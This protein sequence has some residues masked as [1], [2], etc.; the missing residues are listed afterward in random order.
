MTAPREF[1]SFAAVG[2]IGFAVD[3]GVLY[4]AAPA[5]G[6]Y[7]ARVLS[8]V[9]AATATWALNRRYTFKPRGSGLSVGRE[10]AGYLATMLAGALVNYG[11]YVLV[12]Q[13]LDGPWAPAAG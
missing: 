10:Y 4:L 5:F 12:L 1:M 8:F 2:V 9:A 3:V 11:V 7:G 6:W 13:G